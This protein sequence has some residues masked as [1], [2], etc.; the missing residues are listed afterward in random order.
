MAEQRVQRRLA[1][2]LAADVVGYSRLMEQDEAGT[3]ARLKSARS[4]L[5][6]S[7]TTKYGGRVFKTTGDGLLI[8][9]PS[10]VEAVN[11]AI[12]VQREAAVADSNLSEERR[13]AFRIGISL[14]DVIVEDDDLYGNGVNVAARLEAMAEPGGICISSNIRDS[15]GNTI[16]VSF[17][18][19]GDQQVK[20]IERPVRTYAVRLED[21][22]PIGSENATTLE[23]IRVLERPSIAVLP[24]QNM[25]GDPEQEYFADGMVEEIITGLSAIRWLTVIARNSSFFYKGKSPDI[26]QVAKELGVRYVLEGSV[27]KAGDRVRI[28]TQLI[29]VEGGGHL[30]AD[31]FDGTLED[32]FDLQDQITAG[33]VGSIEPSVRK[34]EIQRAKRKRPDNLDA[35]DLY[36]RALSHT[37][38]GTA[39]GRVTALD[40]IDQALKINPDYAEAHGAAAWCYFARSLWEGGVPDSYRDQAIFHVQAVQRLQTE[41]A[42]TLAHAAIALA[43]MTR[44]YKSA[45]DMIDRAIAINPSSVH[46]YGHGAVI[47]TWAG[48]H[49]TAIRLADCSLRLSPFDPLSVMPLAATASARLM[50]GEYEEAVAVARRALQIY[51]TH[52]PSHLI[53]IASLV[54]LERLDEARTAASR[55]LEIAPGFRISKRVSLGVLREFSADLRKAGL[56]E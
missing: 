23:K 39:A 45:L 56:P 54:R 38:E 41:D 35:Y 52:T 14:G 29:E 33:V 2:I 8:E 3:L 22:A 28:A 51:P 40:L 25:S 43:V 4:D 24:F 12:E 34:A 11:C 47:N 26:R 18:D 1:A 49:Q 30:W 17:D 6:S 5:F 32:V 7:R 46:A 44:D 13:I 15:V 50:L 55:L 20:N 31:R 10:A 36:L 53:T 48:N 19:L 27:R 42:S 37:H 21:G 16:G 9:F